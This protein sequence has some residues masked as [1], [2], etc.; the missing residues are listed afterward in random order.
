MA[1]FTSLDNLVSSHPVRSLVLLR[2][3]ISSLFPLA[4]HLAPT[5]PAS[6]LA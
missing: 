2:F 1:P 3:T 5:I 4:L 6:R